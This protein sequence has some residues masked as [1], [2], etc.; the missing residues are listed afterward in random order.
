MQE[1]IVEVQPGGKSKVEVNGVTGGDCAKLTEDLLR[2][3]GTQE[4]SQKKPEFY[5]SNQASQQ[6]HQQGG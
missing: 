1:I 3:L 4:E 6:A 2:A 5:A